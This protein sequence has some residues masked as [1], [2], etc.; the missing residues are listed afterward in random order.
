MDEARRLARQIQ[1]EQRDDGAFVRSRQLAGSKQI[2]PSYD[3]QLEFSELGASHTITIP[4][5]RLNDVLAA[6]AEAHVTELRT[7]TRAADGAESTAARL[8]DYLLAR[9]AAGLLEPSAIV[10]LPVVIDDGSE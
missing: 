9:Q 3:D 7:R 2:A 10:H 5:G 1:R 4:A 8:Q 6:L